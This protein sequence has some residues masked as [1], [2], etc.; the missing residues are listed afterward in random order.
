MTAPDRIALPGWPRLMRVELASRYLGLGETKF[1][2][3]AIPSR[4]IGGAVVWDI[5]ELDRFA[6]ALAGL[7]LDAP[8][9]S[10]EGEGVLNRVRGRLAGGQG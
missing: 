4:Q 2:S 6:S 5:Q 9:R 8:Q 3:L 7:P 1:R 10:A